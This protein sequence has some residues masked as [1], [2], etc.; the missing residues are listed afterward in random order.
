[1]KPSTNVKKPDPKAKPTT[2]PTTNQPHKPKWNPLNHPLLT[3]PKSS[4]KPPATTGTGSTA[5]KP[6]A[7]KQ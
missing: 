7:P 6:T 5:T 1:M 2:A 4:K 3:H